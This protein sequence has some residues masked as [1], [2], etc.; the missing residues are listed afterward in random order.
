ML[1]QGNIGLGAFIDADGVNGRGSHDWIN[2]IVVAV[3]CE[4]AAIRSML[5]RS[6]Y[7]LLSRALET[8]GNRPLPRRIQIRLSCRSWQSQPR[9]SGGYDHVQFLAVSHLPSP[10]SI[11]IFHFH[12]YFNL[13]FTVSIIIISTS[14]HHVCDH[15]H[16]SPLLRT[17]LRSFFL[18]SQG[19]IIIMQCSVFGE[20]SLC[21]TS[22]KE[23]KYLIHCFWSWHRHL[24]LSLQVSDTRTYS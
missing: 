23:W 13:T 21:T 22:H 7:L 3:G 16:Y 4:S 2:M 12:H 19:S 8:W 18:G 6:M 11:F 10:Y 9:P 20:T 1:G 5:P 17:C 24:S 15:R 14:L